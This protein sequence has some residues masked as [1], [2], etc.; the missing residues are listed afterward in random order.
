MSETPTT[1]TSQKSI[2]I[3]LPFVAQC[4][5]CPYALRKRNTVSTLPICIAVRLPFVLP[6]ASHLYRNAFGKILVVVQKA[7]DVWKTDVWDLQE[8][9]E[10]TARTWNS[11]TWPGTPRRPSPRHPWPSELWSPECS[12]HK[13][14]SEFQNELA[15]KCFLCAQIATLRLKKAGGSKRGHL[16]GG[17]LKMGSCSELSLGNSISSVF[18]LGPLHMESAV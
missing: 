8:I 17:H 1:T 16:K 3:H 14:H 5:W 4:F 9:K 13:V 2:A 6:Y 15:Q 11:Q 10:R 12:P 18:F 7:A